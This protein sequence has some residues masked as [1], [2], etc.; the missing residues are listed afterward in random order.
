MA[1]SPVFEETYQKYLA[2]LRGLEIFARADL[3]G[4]EAEGDH[5][6]V[7]L[8]GREYHVSPS[9]ISDPGGREV[10]AA[11][12]V[13][14]CK[15][16]LTCPQQLP[17]LSDRLVTYREF[18]DA[19]PLVSYFTT[20]TNK[21]IETTFAGRLDLLRERAAVAGGEV[22]ASQTYD[23]SLRFLALPRIPVLLNF[24]DRDELFP[25]SASVLYRASAEVFL[26]MECL[27]ITGT[28]LA[29]RLIAP[30]TG[31]RAA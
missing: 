1:K 4:L 30:D 20:N 27:A 19:G 22:L 25:A 17:P 24:N 11:V 2:E 31:P 10:S 12:R 8:Y 7:P 13:V 26:D 23:L 9:G 5:L 29:G 28:L 16:L 15:Y 21:I 3:L 6:R 18:R 14:L